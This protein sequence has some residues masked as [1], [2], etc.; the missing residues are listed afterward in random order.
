MIFICCFIKKKKCCTHTYDCCENIAFL[1]FRIFF[2]SLLN[3]LN[4]LHLIYSYVGTHTFVYVLRKE[5]L[6]Y[7]LYVHKHIYVVVY[8]RA[9]LAMP[10]TERTQ[11]GLC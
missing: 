9:E 5:S 10:L 7:I 11:S 2:S 3:P 8:M 6:A 4:Y 1:R